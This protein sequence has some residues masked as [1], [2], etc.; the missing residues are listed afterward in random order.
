MTVFNLFGSKEAVLKQ[1]QAR[2]EK[3]MAQNPKF[4]GVRYNHVKDN[5]RLSGQMLRIYTVMMKGRWNTLKQIEEATGDP[6][7][8]IS[9]QL[10]NLRKKKFGSNTIE[11]RHVNN[12]LFE[13]RMI[14]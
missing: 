13:Y 7:A 1:K 5:V 3:L 12:G 9:A 6:Q 10:R 11:V 2:F 14:I 8:S 4:N